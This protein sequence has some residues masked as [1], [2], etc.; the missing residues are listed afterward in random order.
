[1]GTR[2]DTQ[3]VNIDGKSYYSAVLTSD[4]HGGMLELYDAEFNSSEF[5]VINEFGGY[6]N[7]KG[8]S[9]GTVI[10]GI[11]KHGNGVISRYEKNGYLLK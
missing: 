7:L 9:E 4:V 6:A 3:F 11:N 8:R 10:M 1:M 5:F 2:T